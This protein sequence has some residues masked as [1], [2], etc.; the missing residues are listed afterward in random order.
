MDGKVGFGVGE[1][2]GDVEARGGV[3]A[4]SNNSAGGKLGRR[5]KI[6]VRWGRVVRG[7]ERTDVDNRTLKSSLGTLLF[8]FVG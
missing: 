3:V 1:N 5:E 2:F 6:V 7:A 8:H 4:D